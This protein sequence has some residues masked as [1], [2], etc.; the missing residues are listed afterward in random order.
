MENTLPEGHRVGHPFGF[1]LQATARQFSRASDDA[2]G[3]FRR[4]SRFFL[5]DAPDGGH[6]NIQHFLAD[7][8]RLGEAAWGGVAAL[9]DETKEALAQQLR[10]HAGSLLDVY[11]A[12]V[13][14]AL[15]PSPD[16]A[17]ADAF[18][19]RVPFF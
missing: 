11:Y 8:M 14:N 12:D 7:C 19:C 5:L 4:A 3:R 1:Y 17:S 18:L 6:P 2:V 9:W 16:R 10:P 13:F 15:G